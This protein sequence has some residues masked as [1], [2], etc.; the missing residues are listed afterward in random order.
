MAGNNDLTQL[1]YP[2]GFKI[3]RGAFCVSFL[4]GVLNGNAVTSFA[5]TALS[6]LLIFFKIIVFDSFDQLK[7]VIVISVF[8]NAIF[9]EICQNVSFQSFSKSSGKHL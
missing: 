5:T 4:V 2:Q 1:F 8:L 7:F 9:C 3:I 6:P